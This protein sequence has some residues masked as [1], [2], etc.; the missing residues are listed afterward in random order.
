M[1]LV[2]FLLLACLQPAPLTLA[3]CGE[4]AVTGGEAQGI[5]FDAA[6]ARMLTH[7]WFGDVI[8]WDLKTL[9]VIGRMSFPGEDV[10]SVAL[11]P[12]EL[13][14][15]IG[16]CPPR[17]P[18][19][20][21]QEA[22]IVD[23]RTGRVV[24][25]YEDAEGGFAGVPELAVYAS[26]LRTWRGVAQD[27]GGLRGLPGPTR[28]DPPAK[29]RWI[30]HAPGGGT[31][32]IADDAGRLHICQAGGA[33][34]VVEHLGHVEAL[35]FTP[36]GQHVAACS[37]G[38]V[39]FATGAGVIV[40][41]VPAVATVATGI[42]G[43]DIWVIGAQEASRF[44]AVDARVLETWTT[45]PSQRVDLEPRVDAFAYGLGP[46]ARPCWGRALALVGGL[47]VRV[48][49]GRMGARPALWS[50]DGL[51]AI[52]TTM[53]GVGHPWRQHLV[54]SH[55]GRRWA[56][57]WWCDDPRLDGFRGVEPSGVVGAF[58]AGGRQTLA[59]AVRGVPTAAAFSPDGAV[60]ALGVRPTWR[61]PEPEQGE[62][63]I[64]LR[65]ARSGEIRRQATSRGPVGW[66]GYPDADTLLA[67]SGSNLEVLDATTLVLRQTI[68]LHGEIDAV[69][70][71]L[72]GTRLAVARGP[73][74]YVYSLTR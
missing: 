69:D 74:V 27:S 65:D 63:R 72:D 71:S 10:G 55:D 29:R 67:L 20:R 17:T 49:T 51:E 45:P 25:R 30:A 57:L 52:P 50:A 24:A 28:L 61:Y 53:P 44:D 40:R 13:L 66:L 46:R 41:R 16:V 70:L 39:T 18:P 3:P 62:P 73:R 31:A 8:L 21:P 54:R 4:F 42:D 7:G 64:E 56:A 32:V 38:A 58:T 22:R 9:E 26:R 59:V 47:A 43:S 34:V 15:A 23:L 11:H 5:D 48:Q 1:V 19:P 14:A 68:D 6:G 2:T 60:L 33:R 35:A 37:S 36:D 12:T